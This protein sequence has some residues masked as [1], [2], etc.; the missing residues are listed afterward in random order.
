MRHPITLPNCHVQIVCVRPHHQWVF[1]KS[2]LS[3]NQHSSV[4]FHLQHFT[5]SNRTHTRMLRKISLGRQCKV[6][7]NDYSSNH[8][9]LNTQTNNYPI[10]PFHIPI[11]PHRQNMY[12]QT[13]RNHH[14]QPWTERQ[15]CTRQSH[16]RELIFCLIRYTQPK[17]NTSPV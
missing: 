3:R 17:E 16:R 14:K 8:P 11:S 10:G 1:V 5:Y 15:T 4:D 13:C 2:K 12:R 7:E 6:A 9:T